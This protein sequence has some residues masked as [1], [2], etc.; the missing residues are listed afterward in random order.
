MRLLLMQA[1]G[2]SVDEHHR[3]PEIDLPEF[4][5]CCGASQEVH[6]M[7]LKG[8][9]R[10]GAKQLATHLLNDR[11]ND[12][13]TVLELRGFASENLNG[14]LREAQAISSATKC[15]QFLF[16]LSLNPPSHAVAGEDDFSRAADAAEKA[17]G[18]AGSARAIIVPRERRD[19]DM[20]M[21]SGRASMPTA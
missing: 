13:V 7:I 10:S 21:S 14:A 2:L 8:S 3:K 11:D 19:G 15:K 5:P 16:S 17:L 18:L 1:L 4:H 20:P 12:H 6:A 9:Q